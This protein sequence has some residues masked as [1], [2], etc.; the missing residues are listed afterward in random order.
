M[1]LAEKQ[2]EL[3]QMYLKKKALEAARA[4]VE[5]ELGTCDILINGAGGNNPRGTTD[6]EYL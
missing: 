6:D 5:K 3:Q 4:I 1:K 2:L